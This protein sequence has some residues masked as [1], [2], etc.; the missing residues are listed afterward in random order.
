VLKPHKF[1]SSSSSEEDDQRR[2][3]LLQ[4]KN[5]LNRD[6][7][8]FHRIESSEEK[9]LRYSERTRSIEKLKM[10]SKK[11]RDLLEQVLEKPK[12]HLRSSSLKSSLNTFSKGSQSARSVKSS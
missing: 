6:I 9:M 7:K 4:S 2:A 8:K 11:V 3:F 5:K 10:E 12:K 1:D